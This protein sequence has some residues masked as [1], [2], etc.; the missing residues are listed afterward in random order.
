MR[1][2]SLRMQQPLHACTTIM[3]FAGAAGRVPARDQQVLTCMAC[4]HRCHVQSSSGSQATLTRLQSE[5]QMAI[6]KIQGDVKAKKQQVRLKH[7]IFPLART[8]V[9]NPLRHW[10]SAWL[11][12][13]VC[14]NCVSR[15]WTCSWAT[16]PLCASSNAYGAPVPLASVTHLDL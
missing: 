5:T 11:I 8:H 13:G 15:W 16:S 1:R 6:S 10:P 3:L 12:C 7:Q 14:C 9:Q 2:R 4:A